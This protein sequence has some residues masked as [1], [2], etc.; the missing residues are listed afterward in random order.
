MLGG[1]SGRPQMVDHH[2]SGDVAVQQPDF[3]CVAVDIHRRVG[4]EDGPAKVQVDR[5]RLNPRLI[6][7]PP[8][9]AVPPRA[10][11]ALAE[12]TP[13]TRPPRTAAAVLWAQHRRRPQAAPPG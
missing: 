9:L 6:L 8:N 11:W 13:A 2:G 3:A 4:V 1:K 10:S 5:R 12:R 7:R